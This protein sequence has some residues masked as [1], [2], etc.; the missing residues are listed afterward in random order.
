MMIWIFIF[1]FLLTVSATLETQNYPPGCNN[2]E[3]KLSPFC[4]AVAWNGICC[5]YP[6]ATTLL[7]NQVNKNTHSFISFLWPPHLHFCT[8]FYIFPRLPKNAKN[9]PKFFFFWFNLSLLSIFQEEHQREARDIGGLRFL[10]VIGGSQK[11]YRRRF[12]RYPG[13]RISSLPSQFP[14]SQPHDVKFI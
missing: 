2:C 5:E 6:M 4:C 10:R 14:S 7:T 13:V 11:R 3:R 1:S 12:I 9:Q 8:T